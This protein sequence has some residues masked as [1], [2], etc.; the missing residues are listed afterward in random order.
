MPNSVAEVREEILRELG[1]DSVEQLF[2]QIPREHRLKKPPHNGTEATFTVWATPDDPAAL[3][4]Y[5]HQ[6]AQ[7]REPGAAIFLYEGSLTLLIRPEWKQVGWFRQYVDDLAGQIEH[8][9]P[10]NFF[11]AMV[12]LGG[13]TPGSQN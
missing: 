8:E 7:G 11:A 4:Q 2:E 10:E 3:V 5:H 1:V 12:P 9:G 6:E 13:T